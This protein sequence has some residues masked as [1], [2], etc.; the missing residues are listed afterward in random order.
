MKFITPALFSLTIFGGFSLAAPAADSA[1]TT[2]SCTPIYVG[3]LFVADLTNLTNT[4]DTDQRGYNIE[5]SSNGDGEQLGK[6]WSRGQSNFI[7]EKCTVKGW[8][9]E[10]KEYGVIR[11]EADYYA[12]QVITSKAAI[13]NRSFNGAQYSGHILGLEDIGTPQNKRLDKQWFNAEYK[14]DKAGGAYVTLE[15]TGN[16]NDK[17]DKYDLSYIAFGYTDE[18][19][20][21]GVLATK[22]DT[23]YKFTLFDVEKI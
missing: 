5:A 4:A 8:N 19:H 16:P 10:S 15:L 21:N 13:D 6:Q 3:K 23:K 20:S 12:K 11:L 22:S 17:N 7:F 18:D 1:A 9:P 14:D 2:V